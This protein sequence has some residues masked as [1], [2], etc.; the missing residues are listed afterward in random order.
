MSWRASAYVKGLVVCPNGE[1]LSRTEKLVALVLAD[2]HQDKAK[3]CTFPSVKMIAEDS[4]MDPRVCRRV[5]AALER[6]GVI[7]RD[8]PEAQGRGQLTFYR[9]PELD[10]KGGQHVPLSEPETGGT[11][12]PF[13][14]PEGGRKEDGRRT[15]QGSPP[16]EEQEQEQIQPTPPT[17]SP[18]EGVQTIADGD[19]RRAGMIFTAAHDALKAHLLND[20]PKDKRPDLADGFG[21]WQRFALSDLAVSGW[22]RDG[23]DS[24][25]LVLESPDKAATERGLAKY[26][27]TWAR[28]VE[29]WYGQGVVTQVVQREKR[30]RG[31]WG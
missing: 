22:T 4:L 13:L 1:R 15:K 19:V 26:A 11:V 2:S 24:A 16:M 31:M 3:A 10:G 8:R 28:I 7:V 12:T 29:R 25:V 18:R 9:F 6:K 20:R 5:L 30:A 21:E 14:L 27:K 17:P 23:P